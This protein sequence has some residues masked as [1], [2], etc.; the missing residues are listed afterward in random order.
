MHRH[1]LWLAGIEAQLLSDGHHRLA[2]LVE[3]RLRRPD[4][5]DRNALG[6][7]ETG[8]ILSAGRVA[9]SSAAA[10]ASA[11]RRVA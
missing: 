2:E 4:V 5:K 8:V 3:R 1:H 7:A 11:G 6:G 9:G 10:Q